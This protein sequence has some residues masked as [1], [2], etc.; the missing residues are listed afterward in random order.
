MARDV[1]L[2]G[3]RGDHVIFPLKSLHSIGTK[4]S[5]KPVVARAG[6]RYCVRQLLESQYEIR[7]FAVALRCTRC[8]IDK[9]N[10]RF[11]PSCSTSDRRSPPAQPWQHRYRCS[12]LTDKLDPF[13]WWVFLVPDGKFYSGENRHQTCNRFPDLLKLFCFSFY[14]FNLFGGKSIASPSRS[15]KV[16]VMLLCVGFN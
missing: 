3:G 7:Q 8:L 10:V 14:I 13:P 16:S 9:N 12:F 4:A 2:H 11:L 5:L 1:P 15:L 6:N